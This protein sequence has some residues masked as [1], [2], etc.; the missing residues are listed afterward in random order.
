MQETLENSQLEDLF[1]I[2]LART[3][4]TAKISDTFFHHQKRLDAMKKEDDVAQE[5]KRL[6]ELAQ[7]YRLILHPHME[8]NPTIALRLRHDCAALLGSGSTSPP[9]KWTCYRGAGRASFA[10]YRIVS[11]QTNLYGKSNARVKSHIQRI[12]FSDHR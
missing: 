11:D 3:H 7:V 10:Y 12:C 9:P 5:V 4:A 6:A 8:D 1:W 2:D